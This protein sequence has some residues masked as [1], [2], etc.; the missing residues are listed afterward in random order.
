MLLK[1]VKPSAPIA[2]AAHEGME[3]TNAVVVEAMAS[4]AGEKKGDAEWN[5]CTIPKPFPTPDRP[6]TK[7]AIASS[8]LI[9]CKVIV[10]SAAFA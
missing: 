2:I 1:T 5:G 9:L 3:E 7:P 4:N 6:P 8:G 10:E